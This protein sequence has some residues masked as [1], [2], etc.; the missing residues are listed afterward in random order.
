MC[1]PSLNPG[2]RHFLCLSFALPCLWA[3]SCGFLWLSYIPWIDLPQ[4]AW[5]LNIFIED[6]RHFLL[7]AVKPQSPVLSQFCA[8][9]CWFPQQ[10][11]GS[12]GGALFP[13]GWCESW[14]T[15][16]GHCG[17]L[18]ENGHYRLIGSG[19]T[20]KIGFEVSSAQARPSVAHGSWQISW[21]LYSTTL[22]CVP[23][24]L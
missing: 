6:I 19:T 23:P 24:W 7:V 1:P 22:V 21:V 11:G 9:G 18:N 12:G 13:I 20:R 17:G 10:W 8:Q 3:E 14:L 5:P 15:W 4:S 2:P 16:V